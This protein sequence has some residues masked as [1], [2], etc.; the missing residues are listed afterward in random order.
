MQNERVTPQAQ[1]NY[2]YLIELNKTNNT[3][4]NNFSKPRVNIKFEKEYKT[5]D[6][7]KVVVLKQ[8]LLKRLSIQ[9]FLAL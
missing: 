5:C 4:K 9:E 8:K 6:L 3:V 7:S 1:S 2:D